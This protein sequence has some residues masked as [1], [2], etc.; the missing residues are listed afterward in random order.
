MRNILKSAGWK[1][2]RE[3]LGDLSLAQRKLSTVG[4][5][6]SNGIKFSQILKVSST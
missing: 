1:M 2:G 5:I 6:P 3:R 4:Q